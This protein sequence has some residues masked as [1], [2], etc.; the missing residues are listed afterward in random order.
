MAHS[1]L[2]PTPI[3]MNNEVIRIYA[4][5]RDGEGVGRVGFVDVSAANPSN[6]IRV[7]DKPCLDIGVPGAFD[8]NGVIP[9]AVVRHEDKLYLYYAGYHLCNK[10]R[11]T[12]FG[13]LAVSSDGGT[14]FTRYSRVPVFERTDTEL[15]FRVPHSVLLEGNKWKFWYGGGDH[16]I[17]EG[18]KSL[19]V[20]DIRY[21]ESENN[22]SIPL[23]S[24]IILTN[25][26][27]DE[28]RVARPYV[29]K[30]QNLYHMF[31]CVGTKSKG[32]RLGYAQS[33]DGLSW[34]RNDQELNL[35][36]SE[37]G[38]DSEMMAYPSVVVAEQGTY[39]F[40]NG[41]DYGKNGFGYAVLEKW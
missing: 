34:R 29:V 8:D 22:F 3:L 26:N 16:F 24:Q 14:S 13:G 39:L 30:Q 36:V 28:H 27:D 10:V 12:V 37:E 1:A 31:I 5:F 40:Y 21:V 20:Y 6:V 32:Y 33:T 41:N 9:S 18:N 2:Q 25:Q 38:W 7:S 19:P 35:D 15:L 4:G 11:F 17:T 23:T